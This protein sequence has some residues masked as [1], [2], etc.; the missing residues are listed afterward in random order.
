[1]CQRKIGKDELEHRSDE[2]TIVGYTTLICSH[3]FCLHVLG[4]WI[5]EN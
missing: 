1:M 3:V 4:I 5:G 2:S